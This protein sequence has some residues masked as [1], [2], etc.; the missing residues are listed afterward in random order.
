MKR[1]ATKIMAT[2][3]LVVG[4]A[5]LAMPSASASP[6]SAQ[7][8]YE[9]KLVHTYNYPNECYVNRD[10]LNKGNHFPD[11]KDQYYYCGNDDPRQLWLRVAHVEG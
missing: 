6:S 7:Y 8:W 11:A 5:L 9:N 10:S 3:S 2:A 4:A 1:V